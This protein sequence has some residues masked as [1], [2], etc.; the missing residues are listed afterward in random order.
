MPRSTSRLQRKYVMSQPSLKRIRL[1]LARSKEFPN[2]ST[3]H[4]YEFVA[5][6]DPTGHIDAAS[7]GKH[8]TNCRVHRFWNGENEHGHLVHRPGGGEHAR[9]VFDYEAAAADDE[10]TCFRFGM[11]TFQTGE[12]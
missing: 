5:P 1:D 10:E 3:R 2:G 6:L 12:Y 11:H 8:R 4:G 9:W 7:W